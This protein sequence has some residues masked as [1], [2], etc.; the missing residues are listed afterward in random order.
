MK[1]VDLQNQCWDINGQ[2]ESLI[3]SHTYS[4]ATK[5]GTKMQNTSALTMVTMVEGIFDLY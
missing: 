5:V 4:I 3:S 2:Y 1:D